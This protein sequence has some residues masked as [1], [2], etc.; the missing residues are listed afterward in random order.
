[1][2]R[3][4]IADIAPPVALRV[5]ARAWRRLRGVG[6]HTFEGSYPSIEAVPAQPFAYNDNDIAADTA[7]SAVRGLRNAG[8]PEPFSDDRC[9]LLLPTIVSQLGMPLTVLDFGGGPA[10]GLI[11]IIDHVRGIDMSLLRYVVVETTEQ[12]RAFEQHKID[13]EIHSEIPDTLPTPLVVNAASV[14]QYIPDWRRTIAQLAH[15]KPKFFIVSQTPVSDQPH[16]A[17]LQL[18]I[19]GK[20]VAQWVF[21]RSEFTDVMS[22]LGY[23]LTFTADHDLP[24][25]HAKASG[26]SQMTSMVFRR[27]S[28]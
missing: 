2:F 14:L 8:H 28:E 25:T 27:S 24:I 9:R 3:R 15:L 18:N 7:I 12:C 5:T 6:W 23:E 10:R 20:R 19:P 11:G 17:R 26:P 13:I 4:L 22:S 21:K 16:Y 1:M